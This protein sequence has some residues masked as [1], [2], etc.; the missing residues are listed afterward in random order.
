M[1]EEKILN[2]KFSRRELLRKAV[3]GGTGIVAASAFAACATPTPQVTKETVVVKE[4]QVVEKQ[5][6][7]VV[8]ATPQPKAPVTL[9]YGLSWVTQTEHH[10][11][12]EELA[13]TFTQKNPNIKVN[14]EDYD[15]QKFLVQAAAKQAPD[16]VI[17]PVPE[18]GPAGGVIDLL[19]YAKSDK[20]FQ[21]E[22]FADVPL[23]DGV[24]RGKLYWI[25]NMTVN[26]NIFYYNKDMFDAAG[27]AQPD[28]D[29]NWTWEY[30]LEACQKFTV[31][32]GDIVERM[33]YSNWWY[34]AMNG[35]FVES[36][37]GRWFNEDATEVMF[38]KPEAVDGLQFMADLTYKY[39]VSPKEDQGPVLGAKQWEMTGFASQ[40]I[41]FVTSGPWEMSVVKD[42]PFKIGFATVP[43]AKKEYLGERIS[44]LGGG[45]SLA[46]ATTS[47]HH[48]EAWQF[49]KFATS[50]DAQLRRMW[51]FPTRR[52]AAERLKQNPP[53]K[54][55]PKDLM[56]LMLAVLTSPKATKCQERYVQFDS[57]FRTAFWKYWDMLRLGQM[58]AQEAM[59]KAAAECNPMLKKWAE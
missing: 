28:I 31:K 56:D 50:A 16:V 29:K 12:E 44:Y 55:W 35:I 26:W 30:F 57:D 49:L 51:N 7:K 14:W 4:T 13:A 6:E 59:D 47:D 3:L 54:Y 24:W 37:H 18:W 27:L 33:G 17:G 34:P 2:Q 45:T 19:P 39:N 48:D 25:P 23:Q 22:D 10:K 1:S 32:K 36:N 43:V 58:S 46:I 5:V 41:A 15:H 9:R 42:A 21:L 8:T 52:S 38:N 11:A 53:E 40:K 20:E